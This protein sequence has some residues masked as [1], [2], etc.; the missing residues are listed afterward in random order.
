VQDGERRPESSRR[1]DVESAAGTRGA[2]K[3]LTLE[4]LQVQGT[5]PVAPS[6]AAGGQPSRGREP[7]IEQLEDLGLP[8]E[9]LGLARVSS[10]LYEDTATL[11][12]LEAVIVAGGDARRAG[13][14][15]L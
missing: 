15:D 5:V 2:G 1:P 13:G 9:L 10:D 8:A 11:A 12:V 3:V 4:R 7:P 6:P 14:H